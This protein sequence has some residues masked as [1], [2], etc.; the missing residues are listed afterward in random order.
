MSCPSTSLVL[1]QASLLDGKRL[2]VPNHVR[3]LI[4]ATIA[5]E[6]AH[7][8]DRDDGFLEPLFLVAVR[9]INEMVRLDIAV[10]VIRNQVVVTVVANSRDHGTKVV[11]SSECALLNLGEH[12]FQIRVNGVFA[13]VVGVAQVL[14]V[15][16]EV[17]EKENVV[18]ADFPGDFNLSPMSKT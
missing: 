13:V 10:E 4:D 1:V 6:E 15:F 14:D 17:T 8:G 18:L 12:P 16:G 11:G 7:A 5:A 3:I 9:L 2:D